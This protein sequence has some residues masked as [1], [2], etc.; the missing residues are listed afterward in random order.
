MGP[1]QDKVAP[2]DRTATGSNDYANCLAAAA[3]N[4]IGQRARSES[5]IPDTM[6]RSAT[7][8]AICVNLK[9]KTTWLPRRTIGQ[10]RPRLRSGLIDGRATGFVSEPN[11]SIICLVMLM[12][13]HGARL[14]ARCSGFLSRRG[15]LRL[16][17]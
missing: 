2:R 4:N 1:A 14:R 10:C 3:R 13:L 6:Q 5:T 8:H 12:N 7:V 15:F 17:A 16:V 11:A 9:A